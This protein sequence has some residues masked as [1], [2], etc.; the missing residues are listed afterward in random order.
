MD[1]R[2]PV[3][4]HCRPGPPRVTPA[5]AHCPP[6]GSPHVSQ[7]DPRDVDAGVEVGEGGV[8]VQIRSRPAGDVRPAGP[9]AT[10][11]P[12]AGW[13]GSAAVGAL[14]DDVRFAPVT[15]GRHRRE[16]PLGVPPSQVRPLWC[17]RLPPVGG[18]PKDR[19]GDFPRGQS[20]CRSAGAR[21]EAPPRDGGCALRGLGNPGWPRRVDDWAP[22]TN[23]LG[24]PQFGGQCVGGYRG[25][26]RGDRKWCHD[27]EPHRSPTR[28]R[29]TADGVHGYAKVGRRMQSGGGAAG[30][31]SGRGRLCGGR[32]RSGLRS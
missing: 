20:R 17:A 11:Y 5:S 7:R 14:I 16:A 27:G 23:R 31:G 32:S 30:E 13:P 22:V 12:G 26:R 15:Y 24:T 25:A 9:S 18:A 19:K 3:L 28:S 10:P 4:G 29:P 2:G 1:R 21:E 8:R 6:R